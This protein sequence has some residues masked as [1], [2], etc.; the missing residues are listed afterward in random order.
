MKHKIYFSKIKNKYYTDGTIICGYCNKQTEYATIMENI[1]IDKT[2]SQNYYCVGCFDKRKKQFGKWEE[3][4][5]VVTTQKLPIDATQ[6]LSWTPSMKSSSEQSVFDI[7]KIQS[8]QTIHHS[9]YKNMG[10]IKDAQIGDPNQ[11]KE[12]DDMRLSVHGALNYLDNIK[13]WKPITSENKIGEDKKKQIENKG[14]DEG[15]V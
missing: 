3:K 1:I 11:I 12:V 10:S 5:I 13:T 15:E 6:I 7:N 9:K 2:L 14:K 8:E 4:I